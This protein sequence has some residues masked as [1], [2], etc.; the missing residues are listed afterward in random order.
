MD[1][2]PSYSYNSQVLVLVT[3]WDKLTLWD[4]HSSE[5]FVF[6]IVTPTRMLRKPEKSTMVKPCVVLTKLRSQLFFSF[7]VF[8]LK[9]PQLSG[10][11]NTGDRSALA[12]S[13]HAEVR[14]ELVQFKIAVV[15]YVGK[16][17]VCW[18]RT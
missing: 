4:T 1:G 7:K 9:G 3:E 2:K 10:C 6:H 5:R 14:A 15:C 18:E 8:L 17:I 11:L 13:E 16:N 12:A